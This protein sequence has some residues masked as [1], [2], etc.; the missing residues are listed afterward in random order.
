[1]DLLTRTEELL[2][3]CV[4]RLR[5]DAYGLSVRREM[6]RLLDRSVSVG[7]VYVPLDRLA[8]RGYLTARD[9]APT[10]RRGGRRKRLYRLTAAGVAA[11]QTVRQVQETAWHGLPALPRPPGPSPA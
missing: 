11:L 3:L 9:G 7:A 2:L 1:M 8:Q 5:D 6:E 4:W 10:G